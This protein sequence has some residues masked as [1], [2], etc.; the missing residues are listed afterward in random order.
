MGE[1]DAF[2]R[3]ISLSEKEVRGGGKGGFRSVRSSLG[4][5]NELYG[6]GAGG[7]EWMMGCTFSFWLLARG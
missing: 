6:L 5:R 2:E 7:T 3:V 1:E 4:G